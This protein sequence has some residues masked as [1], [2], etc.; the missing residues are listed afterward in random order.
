MDKFA[1][2]NM[3]NVG[4]MQL[5]LEAEQEYNEMV[6]QGRRRKPRTCWVRNWLKCERRIAGGG[7]PG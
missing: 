5:L 3:L 2:F 4:F 1:A 7:P 6:V